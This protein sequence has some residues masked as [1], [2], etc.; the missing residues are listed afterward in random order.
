MMDH[1]I[2]FPSVPGLM[3]A[4]DTSWEFWVIW[5][6]YTFYSR[7]SDEKEGCDHMQVRLFLEYVAQYIAHALKTMLQ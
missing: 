2:P 4:A 3:V 1:L 5:Y 6:F 7:V